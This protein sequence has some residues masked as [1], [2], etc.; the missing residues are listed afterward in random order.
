VTSLLTTNTILSCNGLTSNGLNNGIACGKVNTVGGILYSYWLIFFLLLLSASLVLRL[1]HPTISKSRRP[2]MPIFSILKF[3]SYLSLTF[4]IVM[5]LIII[6]NMT[7]LLPL[8]TS[9]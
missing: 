2:K 8:V 4:L 6:C 9:R 1:G 3:I 5:Q 7:Y